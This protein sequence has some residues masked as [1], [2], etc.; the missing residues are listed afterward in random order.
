MKAACSHRLRC[1]NVT[2]CTGYALAAGLYIN[3]ICRLFRLEIFEKSTSRFSCNAEIQLPRESKIGH[4]K[5]CFTSELGSKRALKWSLK[6]EPHLKCV[7]TLCP[8]KKLWSRTLAIT[9]SNLNRFQKFLHCCK[10]K[11]ISN[12]PFF[13]PHLRYVATLPCE[14]QQFETDTNYTQN[15]IKCRHI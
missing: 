11:E 15:T 7:S 2:K 5:I 4:P 9:L 14:I 12:K 3:G 10:E 13:P 1:R 6:I 8:K